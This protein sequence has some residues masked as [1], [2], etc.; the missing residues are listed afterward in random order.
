MM[1]KST[2]NG[3]DTGNKPDWSA[4]C[5]LIV[6]DDFFNYKLLEGWVEMM[7]AQFV[8]AENGQE[9][10]DICQENQDISIVLMD[11]QL[12]GL[13]GYDATRKIK[14]SRPNLP[15]IAVT[16]NAIEEEEIKSKEAGCDNFIAKPVDIKVLTKIVGSLLPGA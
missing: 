9:A 12:P 2:T 15:V 4:Y 8:R 11:V 14:Q 10:V 3:G 6:E 5:I 16:A 7:H 1:N 13:N